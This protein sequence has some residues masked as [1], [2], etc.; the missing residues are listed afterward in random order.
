MFRKIEKEF[1][2][3]CTHVIVPNDSNAEDYEFY[4]KEKD[5]GHVKIVEPDWLMICHVSFEIVN[6]LKLLIE[7]SKESK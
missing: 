3:Q 7:T 6:L 5:C 1:G 2:K 4:K